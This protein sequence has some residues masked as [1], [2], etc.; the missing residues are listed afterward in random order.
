MSD[1]K[2]LTS[3]RTPSGHRPD[4]S[5][6]ELFPVTEVE[7]DGV[8]MGV[9][10]DGTPYLTLRG[11][12]RMCGVDM[13]A[14]Q[15]MATNWQEEQTRPRGFKIKELLASQGYRGDSLFLRV[16]NS[17][18]E[19]HAYTDAVCM[20]VLEYYA[21]ESAQ[22]SNPVALN[23]YRVLARYSFRAFIYNRCGYDPD[24][25]IPESWRN[26][27]ERVILNDQVPINYFSV[28]REIADIVVHL[29]QSGCPLDDHT[30]PDV[31][32]GTM[33]AKHW[34]DSGLEDSYGPRQKHPH[35]YPD[36]FPQSKAN[37]VT[38]WIYPIQAL[39]EFRIWLYENYIRV[40]FP[41]YLES[42]VKTGVFLPSRAELL[43][44][45]V[46]VKDRAQLPG[47]PQQ[48]LPP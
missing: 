10:S 11:L 26:F 32:V 29:I 37:P 22:G 3:N 8:Q 6:L 14:I 9:L 2:E 33:W 42:K 39:G 15:R 30:V 7:I 19:T 23:N 48:E 35:F 21:F 18:Q 31:S 20:A 38:A 17:A 24:K 36:W 41:K 28:F 12:A 40:N 34:C 47:P 4:G 5:Q 43:L 25:H 27:H 16:R 1:I 46:Q 44:E 13:A 45:A